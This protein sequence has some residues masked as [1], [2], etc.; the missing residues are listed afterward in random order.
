VTAQADTCVEVYEVHGDQYT[1]HLS[2]YLA[3]SHSVYTYPCSRNQDITGFFI[4][5][6][7]PITVVAGHSCAFIPDTPS[8]VFFCD[9]I[10]E[11][12]PPISELGLIHI[13][14]PIVGRFADAG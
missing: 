1:R 5:A 8:R 11:H 14:P 7:R 2:V 12:I 4:N 6:T 9:H 3:L 10:V 13:V